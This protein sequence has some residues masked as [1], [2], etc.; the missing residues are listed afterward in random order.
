MRIRQV[1]EN[2]FVADVWI[3][4]PRHCLKLLSRKRPKS[5]RLCDVRLRAVGYAACWDCMR[6]RFE[7]CFRG[8][9]MWSFVNIA[10]GYD[11]TRIDGGASIGPGWFLGYKLGTLRLPV[12]HS[13]FFIF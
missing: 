1:S 4:S 10:P 8:A 11:G 9:Y 7:S 6:L 12:V 13:V 5:C 2:E 3:P